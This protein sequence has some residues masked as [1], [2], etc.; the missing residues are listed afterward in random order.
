MPGE[1]RLFDPVVM[2]CPHGGIGLITTCS[3]FTDT[4][5]LGAARLSDEVTCMACGFIGHI[6]EGS[7]KTIIDGLPGAREGDHE[8]GICCPGCPTCPHSRN[9][10]IIGYS[11]TTSFD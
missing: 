3:D 4:E 1:A 2:C 5:G 9:G 11:P 8:V 6:I 10:V 7:P